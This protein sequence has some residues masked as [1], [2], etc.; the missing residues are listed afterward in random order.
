MKLDITGS[1]LMR[2]GGTGTGVK[3]G[4]VAIGH[5]AFCS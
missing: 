3:I 1:N 5:G 2:D 4:A